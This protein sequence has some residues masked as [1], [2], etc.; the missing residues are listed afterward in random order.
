LMFLNSAS[1]VRHMN[2]KYSESRRNNPEIRAAVT[3]LL[4]RRQA[5]VRE[6]QVL[7]QQMRELVRS[8]PYPLLGDDVLLERVTSAVWGVEN[9]A[10]SYLSSH[11]ENN[12]TYIGN[13]SASVLGEEIAKNSAVKTTA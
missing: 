11:R 3:E 2:Y 9:Q 6:I 4:E 5:T 10:A 13:I 1:I 8:L 7:A 12:E